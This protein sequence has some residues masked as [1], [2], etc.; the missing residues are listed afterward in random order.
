M[1]ILFR[2]YYIAHYPFSD[3]PVQ[4]WNLISPAISV[5]LN[6]LRDGAVGRK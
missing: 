3:L 1:S 5:L 6:G 4:V 2:S